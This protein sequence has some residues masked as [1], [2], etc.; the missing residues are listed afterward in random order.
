MGKFKIKIKYIFIFCII[1]LISY[2]TVFGENGILRLREIERETKKIK[3]ACDKQNAE[4]EKLKREIK[5][6]QED[7]KYIEK[8]AREELGMARQDEI[9]YKKKHVESNQ[10]K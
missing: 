5:L 4:N 1:L 7:T 3:T 10:K 6:L 8:I 9:I 2:F